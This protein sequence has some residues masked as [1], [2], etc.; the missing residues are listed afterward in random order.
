MKSL[1][2]RRFVFPFLDLKHLG[3]C[4]SVDSDSLGVMMSVSIFVCCRVVLGL[5]MVALDVEV[6]DWFSFDGLIN[7][8]EHLL[9]V[10]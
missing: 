2:R 4:M 7:I 6:D 8:L 10:H 9:Q 5:I 3:G 1:G